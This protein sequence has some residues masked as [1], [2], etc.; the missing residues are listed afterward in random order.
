MLAG[1]GVSSA[2]PVRNDFG[3]VI[4]TTKNPTVR[5]PASHSHGEDVRQDEIDAILLSKQNG[6]S[7]LSEMHVMRQNLRDPLTAHRG[8]G[9][10]IGQAVGLVRTGFVKG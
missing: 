6:E 8:H 7:F 3:K 9:D 5:Q 10:T 4:G 1:E 2:V